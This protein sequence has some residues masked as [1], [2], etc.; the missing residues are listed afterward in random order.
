MSLHGNCGVHIHCWSGH[1][2]DLEKEHYNNWRNQGGRHVFS[3]P[4]SLVRLTPRP[5]TSATLQNV[6]APPLNNSLIAPLITL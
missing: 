4:L 5:P 6:C 1:G 3:P 2:A